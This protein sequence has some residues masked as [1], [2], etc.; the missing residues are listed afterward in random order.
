MRDATTNGQR[1]FFS[2]GSRS[3]G[4]AP[5]RVSFLVEVLAA[6]HSNLVTPVF[7]EERLQML[8][9]AGARLA[10]VALL[11]ALSAY[12]IHPTPVAS[13]ELDIAATGTGTTS[14]SD[15]EEQ[16]FQSSLASSA[17][18]VRADGSFAIEFVNLRSEPVHLYWQGAEVR[19][20]RA[21]QRFA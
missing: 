10:L 2:S 13:S 20:K 16:V 7:I 4:G 9:P 18:Q 15:S 5:P 6:L 17:S 8:E 3:E 1:R 19:Q 21:L 11:C 12:L 14:S